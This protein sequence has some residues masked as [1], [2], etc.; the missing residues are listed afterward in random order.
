MSYRPIPKVEVHRTQKRESFGSPGEL[1]WIEISDLVVDTRYQRDMREKGFAHVRQIAANFDWRNFTP[2]I[3]APIGNRRFAVID[4][5]HRLAA[6]LALGLSAAPCWI[7]AAEDTQQASAF[8]AI[9]AMGAKVFTGQLWHSRSV[10]GDTQAM[11]VFAVADAAKIE[12]CKYVVRAD[13]RKPNQCLAAASIASAIG[14]YGRETTIRA[15]TILRRAGEISGRN[16]LNSRI[17][18]AAVVLAKNAWVRTPVE[19]CAMAL[20]RLDANE[21][22]ATAAVDAK[23]SGGAPAEFVVTALR[24]AVVRQEKAA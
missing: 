7:V 9:N 3:A 23:K 1:K 2:V 17:I 14:A 18:R 13:F 5:Q 8:M 21:V 19:I 10:A 6:A 12:I 20:A 16:Y 4:G 22:V 24:D 15:L 11:A